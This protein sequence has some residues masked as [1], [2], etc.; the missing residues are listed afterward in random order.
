MGKKSEFE[1]GP[2]EDEG[3]EDMSPSFGVDINGGK[4]N[5]SSNPDLKF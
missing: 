2:V 3:G 4:K 1:Y 5:Y